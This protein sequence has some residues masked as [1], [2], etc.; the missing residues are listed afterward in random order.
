MATV[1]PGGYEVLPF[2]DRRIQVVD[3]WKGHFGPDSDTAS[4]TPDGLVIDILTKMAVA[5][6]E[7]GSEAYQAAFFTTAVGL[8]L[9]ALLKPLFNSERAPDRGSAGTITVYGD[10]GTAIPAGS[11]ASTTGRGDVYVV[12][13]AV[14]LEFSTTAVVVF[15]P[16]T[17]PA[18]ST[19]IT[20]AGTLYAPFGVFNGTGL[21]VAQNQK[22]AMPA[23]DVNILSI[24]EAYEDPAGNG[25]LV[26]Q[27]TGFLSAIS[28]ASASTVADFRGST[29]TVTSEE[30]GAIPG[31]AFT[32]TTITSGPKGWEGVTNLETVSPGALEDTDAQ[33]RARHLATLGKNG[34]G[35]IL[36][37][38]GQLRDIR[39]NP[40]VESVEVYN[41]FTGVTDANGL[42][43]HS[44]EVV[45]EG[46]DADTIATIIWEDH[47]LGIESGGVVVKF[48]TDPRAAGTHRI[49]FTL[50]TDRHVWCDV[51]IVAG[52]GFPPDEISD[53]EEAVSNSLF[54]F[55]Q[56]LGV[57]R[58]IYIDELKQKIGIAG[59]ASVT[60][61]LGTRP[62][63][64][65]SKPALIAANIDIAAREL[66]I[67]DIGKIDVTVTV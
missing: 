21:Q 43:P 8:Q 5:V 57:G 20:I 56:T 22:A 16:A 48:I 42:P 34:S 39:L 14:E 51:A 64:T 65:D 41:N 44:Y 29:T 59:V 1:E 9:D 12:D 67:W 60:I 52:E 2:E 28:T 58:D 13:T 49:R 6:D 25:V 10:L 35:T 33:Y 11:E 45:I 62:L 47:Q 38:L 53:I 36:S 19:T 31:D 3:L 55:G 32:I 15:G 54:T 61:S 46:G 17:G 27:L 24:S 4:E 7:R 30:P 23:S 63:A 40:G 66:S 26:I 18:T 37:L 50:P